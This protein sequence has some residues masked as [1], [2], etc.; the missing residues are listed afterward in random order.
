MSTRRQYLLNI[1]WSW[2]GALALILS[3]FV[4]APY[5]IRKLGSDS[6]GI[7]A[8]A[9][10]FV[11]YLWLIDL[12][13]RPA[14]IKL[15]AEYRALENWGALNR[16]INTALAYAAFTG[17]IIL[18]I[19]S[20][21]T[22]AIARFFHI[23]EP[24]FP[25]LIQ[26]VS[27]SWALGLIANVFAAGLEA[28]QRF[29]TTN[30]ILVLF[31]IVRSSLLLMLVG[32]GFGLTGMAFT[33]FATQMLMY[34]AFYVAFRAVYPG[35]R[36]SA[37]LVA[38]EQAVEIWRYARQMVPAAISFRLLQGGLPALIARFLPVRN[39][40][41][42]TVTLK[43]VDY[44]A[45][46][47]GRLGMIVTPRASDWMARGYRDNILALAR[48]GNRYALCLWLLFATFLLVYLEP[49]F[50]L[51]INVEFAREATALAPPLLVAYTLWMGQF[52]SASILTGIGR[53][54]RFSNSLLLEAVITLIAFAVVLPRWGLTAGVTVVATFIAAN[55]FLN[56][57]L[58]FCREFSLRPISFLA[59]IYTVPL[60]LAAL[61]I[62]FLS[63]VQYLWLPGQSWA[64]V[65]AAG[66]LNSAVFGAAVFWLVAEP[67]HRQLVFTTAGRR[68]RML[69][70]QVQPRNP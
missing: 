53:Y 44:G 60:A 18:L 22:N 50:R 27:V 52:I 43:V 35:L 36:L 40:T 45:E 55:R 41:Y 48:Y 65:M 33:L 2:T 29:D 66:A 6:Y 63:L 32:S 3:G 5:L 42:F 54:G 20:L 51:W 15:G 13:V 56:L 4:V 31:V 68:W 38:R 57:S 10:S 19:V 58:I 47:I 70:A 25:L 49:L 62:A 30:H 61:D 12:G 28:F 64:E 67:V 14:T 7:W 17:V 1:I 69:T 11:E 39:V 21:N 34:A 9:L 16:L 46:A 23:T 59:G 37:G 8:L 26:V 24:A